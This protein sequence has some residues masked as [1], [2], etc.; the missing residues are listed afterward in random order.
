MRIKAKRSL[1]SLLSDDLR[2]FLNRKQRW[3]SAMNDRTNGIEGRRRRRRKRWR[4]RLVCN[5]YKE[6]I[7]R[8]DRVEGGRHLQS[9]DW[10]AQNPQLTSA[11]LYAPRQQQQQQQQTTTTARYFLVSSRPFFSF[12]FLGLKLWT[13]R[14]DASLSL[15]LFSSSF[16]FHVITTFPFPSLPLPSRTNERKKELLLVTIIIIL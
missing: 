13:A 6:K 8:I 2:I 7:Y 5:M 10:P 9:L 15:S 4:Q 1:R 11:F 14:A 16:F 12:F 3:T